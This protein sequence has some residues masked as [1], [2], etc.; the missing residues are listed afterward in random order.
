VL[1]RYRVERVIGEGGMSV[2]L[3]VRHRDT[4]GLFAMKVLKRSLMR[5]ATNKERFL[6]EARMVARLRSEHVVRIFDVGE[7]SVGTTYLLMEYLEGSDLRRVLERRGPLS[8]PE[9]IDWMLHA[10]DALTEAHALGIVHRDL[11]P[12]NLFVAAHRDFT[13]SIKVLDFGISADEGAT[14]ASSWEG[15]PDY[16]APE[17]LHRTGPADARSDLWSL[18]VIFHELLVQERPSAERVSSIRERR[19]DVPRDL[20]A[21][22]LR[23]L[24][25]EVDDRIQAAELASSLRRLRDRLVWR[26]RSRAPHPARQSMRMRPEERVAKHRPRARRGFRRPANLI[27]MPPVAAPEAPKPALAAKTQASKARER[28]ELRPALRLTVVVAI[29]ALLLACGAAGLSAARSSSLTP[30]PG[31]PGHFGGP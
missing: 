23:C 5:D 14:G 2:V 12:E 8:I 3:A 16:T 10:L 24:T 20:D 30:D 17:E 6:L 31:Q 7:L 22:I 15:A 29:C 11:K 9:A 28:G 13:T 26:R 21:L 19:P 1:G 27:A 18:G 25:P 4:G